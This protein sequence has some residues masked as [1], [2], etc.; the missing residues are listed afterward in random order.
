MVIDGAYSIGTNEANA[1][2]I[3]AKKEK[4]PAVRV[5]TKNNPFKNPFL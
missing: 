1:A 5:G 3:L 2:E 4:Y